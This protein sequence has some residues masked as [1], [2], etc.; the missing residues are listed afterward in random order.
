M[1]K[2]LARTKAKFQA[3]KSQVLSWLFCRFLSSFEVLFN[4]RLIVGLFL[5]ILAFFLLLLSDLLFVLVR[6]VIAP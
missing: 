4:R 5:T 2:R 6:R 1:R 3:Q